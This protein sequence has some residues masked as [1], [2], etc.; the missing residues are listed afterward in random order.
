MS[1]QPK[2]TAPKDGRSI[3]VR[4]RD[5]AYVND[6]ASPNGFPMISVP[7]GTWLHTVVE[8]ENYNGNA[9]GD[10]QLAMVGSYAEDSDGPDFVEWMEIPA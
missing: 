7:S 5:M 6:P 8:W 4:W 2:E 10:W 9:P 3:L 1:W